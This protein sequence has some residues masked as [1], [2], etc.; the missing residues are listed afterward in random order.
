[1]NTNG[2]IRFA[3]VVVATCAIMALIIAATDSPQRT[4]MRGFMR[5]KLVHSQG[6]LEGLALEQFDLIAKN[7][8]RLRDMSQSNTWLTIKVVDYMTQTTNYQKSIDALYLAATTKDLEA[9]TEAYTK[10]ARDCVACHRIVRSEQHKLGPL[11]P[12]KVIEPDSI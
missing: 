11:P 10:V 5:Q 6:I 2:M 12:P 7:A 3:A 8:V 4:A 9:A 1:M